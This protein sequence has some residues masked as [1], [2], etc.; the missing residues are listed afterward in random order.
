MG[1]A[2]MFRLEESSIAG[3]LG[4]RAVRGAADTESIAITEA[5]ALPSFLSPKP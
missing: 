3:H 4:E 2:F 5:G 1:L